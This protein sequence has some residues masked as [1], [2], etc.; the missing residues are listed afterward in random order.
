V[1]RTPETAPQSDS[2]THLER[3]R[4]A[5]LELVAGWLEPGEQVLEIGAGSGYQA[6]LLAARG[7]KVTALDVRNRP[8]SAKTYYAVE[9]YDGRTIPLADESVDVV[10]SSHALEHVKPLAPLLAETHR[11]M[12]PTGV[13]IHVLPSAT[14]RIGTSLAHY[15]FVL[16][17][18]LFGR[19][20]DS[21]V[22]IA[23]AGDAIGRHGVLLAICKT[24][25]HPFV[26]HGSNRN[27]LVEIHAFSRARWTTV[28]MRNGF[29]IVDV[30]PSK[31]F[32]TG[33][34]LFTG[35]SLE[36]RQR[37]SALLGS[38]SRAFVLRK[39]P[40]AQCGRGLS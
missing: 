31:L 22:N 13:G 32:Y 24:A 40:G 7:C 29:A 27:A 3:L 37:I 14:W 17:T 11:V 28:F 39:A 26:A 30:L 25:A 8:R 38:A 36:Q 33:Y 34:G 19:K 9:E 16:K 21:L 23:S 1:S 4:R 18:L 6:S 20:V 35:I 12:K 2:L 5:E 10:F 15:P